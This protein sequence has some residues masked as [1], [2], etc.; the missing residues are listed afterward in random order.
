VDAAITQF[1]AA[2]SLHTYTSL[3]MSAVAAYERSHGHVQEA[4]AEYGRALDAAG[5]PKT[6]SIVLSRLSSIF[7]QFGDVNRAKL[8]CEEA[9]K[10]NSRNGSALVAC[11]LLAE[12]EGD[13][14]TAVAQISQGMKVEPTDVGYLL[15]AHALGRSGDTAGANAASA[16]AQR[17]SQNIAEG[18]LQSS[19]RFSVAQREAAEIL[20][21]SGIPK[22]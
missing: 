15:L 21:T 19:L 20:A 9:L 18:A 5:D 3:D 22:N 10:E 13:L 14:S 12:H 17:I 7:L 2:E 16:Q 1:N 6:R 4:F 11:G 8:T